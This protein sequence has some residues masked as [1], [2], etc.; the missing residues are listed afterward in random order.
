MVKEIKLIVKN[1]HITKRQ[2][3]KLGREASIKNLSLNELIRRILDAHIDAER[4]I[5]LQDESKEQK[6]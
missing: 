2:D 4:M 3:D 5:I 1:I 6:K